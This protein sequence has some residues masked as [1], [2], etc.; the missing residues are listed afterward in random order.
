MKTNNERKQIFKRLTNLIR[1]N[2]YGFTASAKGVK[3]KLK[4]G[5]A[6]SITNNK[7]QNINELINRVLNLNQKLG[8][9]V[10]GWKDK[11]TNNFYLDL[12]IIEPSRLIAE[13]IAKEF[14][15]QAIFDFGN[16]SE[17]RVR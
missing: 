17:I 11:Q 4:K 16:L 2:P 7:E 13:S 10:G 5:Y 8:F 14:K 6:V 1:K 15:Q 3:L 12:T 9:C